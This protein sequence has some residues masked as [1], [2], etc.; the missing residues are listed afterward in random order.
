VNLDIFRNHFLQIANLYKL[1]L[2]KDVKNEELVSE[3]TQKYPDSDFVP[4]KY[5]FFKT[6]Q[7]IT[8]EI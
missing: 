3:Y 8:R 1:E 5:Q 4:A 6:H 2:K 7:P